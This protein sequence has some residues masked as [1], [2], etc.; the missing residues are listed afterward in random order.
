MEII[1]ISEE[2]F[3]R[4]LKCGSTYI[5]QEQRIPT[6]WMKIKETEEEWLASKWIL[7]DELKVSSDYPTIDEIR[8]TQK[9]EN[10]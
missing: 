7:D 4:I 9:E 10:K 1:A 6:V 8:E 5:L 2:E 3:T